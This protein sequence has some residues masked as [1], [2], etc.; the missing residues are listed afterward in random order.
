MTG[1][2]IQ[3]AMFLFVLAVLWTGLAVYDMSKAA[4]IEGWF[5]WFAGMGIST[6]TGLMIIYLPM[7]FGILLAAWF[8]ARRKPQPKPG[9][10]VRIESDVF[11]FRGQEASVI[12]CIYGCREPVIL[13]KNLFPRDVGPDDIY[14]LERS[15]GFTQLEKG[16]TSSREP[17]PDAGLLDVRPLVD[18][19][20]RGA[21]V[22]AVL[23]GPPG[24]VTGEEIKAVFDQKGHA[25]DRRPALSEEEVGVL[26]RAAS[27]AA[28]GEER[29]EREF[30]G[31]LGEAP[32]PCDEHEGDRRESPLLVDQLDEQ[33]HREI[34][35][36]PDQE[37]EAGQRARAL[38]DE[39]D[40]RGDG[41]LSP[42]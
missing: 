23:S 4:S 25:D 32:E 38:G 9:G 5:G 40:N 14:I 21:S 27:D 18:S 10:R 1:R 30:G 33:L 39:E 17:G 16:R 2:R 42:I 3:D 31:I 7:S 24:D 28:D 35:S 8:R 12:V 26:F 41:P 19:D 22:A 29:P 36:P 6:T 37:L 11:S 34:K 13:S 20:V 15:G